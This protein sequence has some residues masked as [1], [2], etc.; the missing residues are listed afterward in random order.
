MMNLSSFRKADQVMTIPYTV[1][2]SEYYMYTFLRILGIQKKKIAVYVSY[3]YT[4]S[5]TH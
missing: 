1:I 5:S 2:A 4:V 3:F